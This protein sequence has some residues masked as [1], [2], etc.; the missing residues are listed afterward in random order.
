MRYSSAMAKRTTK[1]KKKSPAID[2]RFAFVPLRIGRSGIHAFGVFTEAEIP[3]G[4]KIIEYTGERLTLA[5]AAARY[6][7]NWKPQKPFYLMKVSPTCM[8]DAE[9]R[10]SG[11]ER[12]NHSCDPNVVKRLIR[13]RAF[14]FA[15]RPIALGEELTLDYNL[16]AS[17]PHY[18][19][20][21]GSAN[22]RG[23]FTRAP[24]S[25]SK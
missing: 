1:N 17:M 2:P 15:K 22:C 20:A 7:R 10:G 8:I 16:R 18:T 9:F 21:C 14:F 5:E 13:G 4:A 25:R 11:A 23:T 6:R 12:I 3:R 19:C 24:R